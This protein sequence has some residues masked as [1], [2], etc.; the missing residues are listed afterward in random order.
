MFCTVHVLEKR[1]GWYVIWV[2][3]VSMKLIS[4]PAPPPF[5]PVNPQLVVSAALSRWIWILFRLC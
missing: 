4:L 1:A 3:L 5:L 2:K